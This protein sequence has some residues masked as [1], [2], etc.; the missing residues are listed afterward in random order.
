MTE[1]TWRL[2]R[3]ALEQGASVAVMFALPF[4]VAAAIV[5]N[6]RR[7]LAAVLAVLALI[8]L[9]LGAGVAAWRQDRGTPYTHG[10]LTAVGVFVV[11]QAI[12]VVRRLAAGDPLH[13]SR[14]VS[15]LLLSAFAGIVGGLMGSWAIKPSGDEGWRR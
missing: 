14:I 10:L 12:G 9:L 3:H 6:E 15:G 2:D 1:L 8:G 13:G 7:G 11:I 4:G 5:S